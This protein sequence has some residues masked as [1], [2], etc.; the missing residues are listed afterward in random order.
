M[1]QDVVCIFPISLD[2]KDEDGVKR[3]MWCD[4]C[5]LFI[6]SFCWNDVIL[7]QIRLYN[8]NE[9]EIV[10]DA[11]RHPFLLRH[12]ECRGSNGE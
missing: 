10:R 2:K 3:S 8:K 5:V 7:W 6:C 12:I 4:I 11:C 1:K 9:T